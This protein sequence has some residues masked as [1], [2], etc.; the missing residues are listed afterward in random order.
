MVQIH[1]SG[2]NLQAFY[3]AALVLW[4]PK[5]FQY[6]QQKWCPLLSWSLHGVE[7][8][9]LSSTPCEAVTMV[10]KVD[11]VVLKDETV[12]ELAAGLDDGDM[13]QLAV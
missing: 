8:V 9:P 3:R 7:V 4:P 5:A 2:R 10:E 6:V 11:E 1:W 12:S 13:R